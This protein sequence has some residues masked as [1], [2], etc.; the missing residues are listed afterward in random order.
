MGDERTSILVKFPPELL[1]RVEAHAKASELNRMATI[2]SLL[3]LALSEVSEAPA[4]KNLVEVSAPRTVEKLSDA[5]LEAELRRR[6]VPLVDYS[7]Q[8]AISG[9]ASVGHLLSE[10]VRPGY[11]SLLKGPKGKK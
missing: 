1:A 8:R 7:A 5:E 10:P 9:R 11:G 6:A 3:D 4:G 2:L